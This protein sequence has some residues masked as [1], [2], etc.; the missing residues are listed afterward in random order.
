VRNTIILCDERPGQRHLALKGTSPALEP[1]V[2]CPSCRCLSTYRCTYVVVLMPRMLDAIA[3]CKS[4]ADAGSSECTR[5]IV[6]QNRA[7]SALAAIRGV[8]GIENGGG[9]SSLLSDRHLA[10][11]PRW[12]HNADRP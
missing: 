11:G 2:A 1:S 7:R 5:P 6:R 12:A 9:S 8:H 4:L 10:G 3:S